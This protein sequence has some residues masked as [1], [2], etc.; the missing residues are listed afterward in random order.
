[1]EKIYGW[2]EQGGTS[3]VISGTQGSG[4]QRFQ[5][6][7][8]SATITIYD[9]GTLNLSTIYS[10]NASPPTA[11]AN[12]FTAS[13]TTGYWE[14]YVAIGQY[15]I[16][17]SGGSILSPFTISS[18]SA[19]AIYPVINATEM[20]G[21]NAG[22]K[23]ANAITQL[24]STGGTVDARGF[25]GTGHAISTDVFAGVSKPVIVL[26]GAATFTVTATQNIPSGSGIIGQYGTT[27]FSGTTIA[28]NIPIINLSSATN[29]FIK[30]CI[31]L[32]PGTTAPAAGTGSSIRLTS[33]TT[34]LIEDVEL[35]N[36]ERWGIL[37]TGS[38]GCKFIKIKSTTQTSRSGSTDPAN[39]V[40]IHIVD[41]SFDNIVANC[42]LTGPSDYGITFTQTFDITMTCK[43]NRAVNNTVSGKYLGGI[44]SYSNGAFGRVGRNTISNNHVFTIYGRDT[45]AVPGQAINGQGIYLSNTTYDIVDANNV[46]DCCKSTTNLT[47]EAGCIAA[48]GAAFVITNNICNTCVFEGISLVAGSGVTPHRYI[49]NNNNIVSCRNGILASGV[50]GITASGNRGYDGTADGIVFSGCVDVLANGNTTN[51]NDVYGLRFLNCTNVAGSGNVSHTNVANGVYVSGS[52]NVNLNGVV[53]YNNS[54]GSVGTYAG[55]ESDTTTYLTLTNVTGFDS[56]GTPTQKYAVQLQAT[57]TQL[58]YSG[59]S[60]TANTAGLE[61][62]LTNS[63]LA[64]SIS[65]TYTPTHSALT[66]LAATTAY[67]TMYARLGNL[68]VISGRFDA[69]PTLATTATS[70][71]MTLPIASNI[72]STINVSGQAVDL[73]E[74]GN[75]AGI[76]GV[77]ANDTAI[78]SWISTASVN[79]HEWEFTLMYR[80]L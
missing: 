63:F 2:S 45:G 38:T 21:A 62:I 60:G 79:N 51:G 76:Y 24:P 27:I 12:P 16:K 58:V 25:Q 80:I 1:M 65:G 50:T 64:A 69:D 15:D 4:A 77:I 71:E 7:F 11:K 47:N 17:F 48:H 72:A 39:T 53:V 61:N 20:A 18:V 33:C 41:N 13:S 31:V 57:V 55:F 46:E 3:V 67:L 14:F 23:I 73:S 30:S 66:N 22:A 59:T 40:D 29:S 68:V 26:F 52:T 10:D 9:A 74:P 35:R 8:R 70:F 56:Q 34:C 37:V 36:Y 44:L 42:Y 54:F 6:S 19:S 49:V 43:R 78:V 32:G 5:Q 28:A 75:T